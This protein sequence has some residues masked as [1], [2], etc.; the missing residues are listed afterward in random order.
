MNCGQTCIAPDYILCD[1]S[2]QSKVVE[3][4]KATLQVS[5]EFLVVWE[6]SPLQPR[7]EICSCSPGAVPVVKVCRVLWF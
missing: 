7:S 4:I 6:L 5:V 2:I 1:P 3:N